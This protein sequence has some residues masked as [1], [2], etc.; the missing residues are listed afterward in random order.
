MNSRF[1]TNAGLS[2]LGAFTV[3]ASM[4]WAPSTFMW[5]MFAAGIVAVA[6]SPAAAIRRRGASQRALDGVIAILGAWTIV[7]SLVFSA[8]TV[9]WLGFASGVGFVALALAGLTLHELRTERVVHSVEVRG[10]ADERTY[11]PVN[12]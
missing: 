4:A 10:S 11:A 1:L 2:L 9:T 5:L 3:V 7:A 6:L 8:G 12:G